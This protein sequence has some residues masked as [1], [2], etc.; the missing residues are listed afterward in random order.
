MGS[1]FDRNELL[2]SLVLRLT[3][4][5]LPRRGIRMILPDTYA[6]VTSVA[7]PDHATGIFDSE[8]HVI[9]RTEL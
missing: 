1:K 2:T 3:A 8:E 4:Y 6:V 5:D 7:G 9:G